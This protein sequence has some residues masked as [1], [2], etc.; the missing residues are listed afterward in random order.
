M[1]RILRLGHAVGVEHKRIAVAEPNTAGT[2]NRA[3]HDAER[4]PVAGRQQLERAAGTADARRIMSGVRVAD[5][6]GA[7]VENAE[8]VSDEHH[9]FVVAAQ[10]LVDARHQRAGLPE[11]LRLAALEGLGHRHEKSGRNP[12][13]GNIP[14]D[15][16]VVEFIEIE[17]V[18]EVPADLP[19]RAQRCE[20][21]EFPGVRQRRQHARQDAH[22]NLSGDFKL[23]L[24]AF[25]RRG[26]FADLLRVAAERL[27]HGAECFGE[28]ADLVAAFRHRQRRIE[29]AGS[30]RSGGVGEPAERPGQD[31]D[32]DAGCGQA[33]KQRR[34]RD[35][36]DA[37]SQG[38]QRR[39]QQGLR[40]SDTET[41][42]R[43][44]NRSV[45]DPFHPGAAIENAA[46]RFAAP[47][48]EHLLPDLAEP[49]GGV[50]A[51]EHLRPQQVGITENGGLG[52]MRGLVA[53]LLRLVRMRRVLRESDEPAEP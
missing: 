2:V 20:Q 44:G 36:H 13:V 35:R 33:E 38:I 53:E 41:P 31:A 1:P 7:H 47:A 45:K 22:L 43:G 23:A 12:L 19:G 3:G 4:G 49:P 15:E 46:A 29:V 21:R 14:D 39:H 51:G 34:G 24:D 40:I 32:Q 27:L 26:R 28:P 6:P 48:P 42:S 9:G 37:V 25:A 11:L 10:E 30:D 8:E 52:Q 16:A 17:E 18:I 5:F 50:V